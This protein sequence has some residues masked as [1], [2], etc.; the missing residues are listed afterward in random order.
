MLVRESQR[1]QL[2][3]D[4]L[5]IDILALGMGTANAPPFDKG[6][7]LEGIDLPGCEE[8]EEW[9]RVQRSRIS[10]LLRIRL[11]APGTETPTAA[12]VLGGAL[13]SVSDL[14]ETRPPPIPPKPSVSVLPFTN[15]VSREADWLGQSLADEIGMTL[16]QFPQLFVVAS[17][18]ALALAQRQL[19]HTDIATQ[20]GVRYLLAGSVRHANQEI[21]IAVRLIDG[22]TGQQIW[23][24]TFHTPLSDV[25][26]VEDR[27][28]VAV[29]PQIWTNIDLA[30]RTRGITEP[31]RE[32]N[33]YELYWRANGLLRTWS[34]ENTLEA[35]DIAAEL[36]QLNPNCALSASLAGFCHGVAYSLGWTA[37]RMATRRAAI[38]HYQNAMRFGGSNIEALGYAAG[39]LVCIGGDM[40]LADQ[41]IA[42]ALTLLPAYQPTLFWGGWVDIATGNMERARERFELSLRINPAAG[43]RNFAMTG[44]G[45]TYLMSGDA[46]TSYRVLRVAAAELPHYP[47]AQAALAVAAAQCGEDMVARE[48]VEALDA[49]DGEK[50]VLNTLQ[51]ERFQH[52]IRGAL[53][54]IR[55][56]SKSPD[57]VAAE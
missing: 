52:L 16:A 49:I 50:S 27:I 14:L 4:H 40:T 41:L 54:G 46:I 44:I 35:I 11:P 25:A 38:G 43:V 56:A 20:L 36:T 23:G 24:K 45:V 18:A 17:T 15:A 48:A 31:I 8:F 5:E 22:Q 47:V 13:P 6:D 37:D 42:H 55:A 10:D 34:R 39:T 12:A 29:A 30:E 2:R 32:R 26:S 57:R 3:L 21:R 19:T 53:A 51:D 1:V 7:L 9:L 28:A 33:S